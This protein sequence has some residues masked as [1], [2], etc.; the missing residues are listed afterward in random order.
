[1][2]MMDVYAK[3]KSVLSVK[4][5]SDY[6]GNKIEYIARANVLGGDVWHNVQLDMNKFK[7]EEGMSLKSYEKINAVE[8]NVEGTEYLI[9]NVLWV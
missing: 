1:M 4:L 6:A 3:E 5:I 9:N 2:L 8:F 7:T